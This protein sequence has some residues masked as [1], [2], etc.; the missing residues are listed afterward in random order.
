MSMAYCTNK[1]LTR[2]MRH[3]A[4]DKYKLPGPSEAAA[5]ED[6]P[7]GDGWMRV[8]ENIQGQCFGKIVEHMEKVQ[9]MASSTKGRASRTFCW[10]FCYTFSICFAILPKHWPGCFLQ[11][12]SATLRKQAVPRTNIPS[13]SACSWRRRLGSRTVLRLVSNMDS[14]GSEIWSGQTSGVTALRGPRLP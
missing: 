10:P 2:I 1:N 9:K 12:E 14:R 8:V 11:G 6:F 5:C 7:G 3:L 4:V 13:L